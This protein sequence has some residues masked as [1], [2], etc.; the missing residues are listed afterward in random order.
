MMQEFASLK[1][2]A[3]LPGDYD[4]YPG[5]MGKTQLSVEREYNPYMRR[6]IEM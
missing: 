3:Q 4:V 2:L 5:H 1:K 6:A